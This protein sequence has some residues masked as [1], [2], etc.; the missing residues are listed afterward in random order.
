MEIAADDGAEGPDPVAQHQARYEDREHHEG[1]R[2][3]NGQASA[4]RGVGKVK[5]LDIDD[6]GWRPGPA[7]HDSL[8]RAVIAPLFHK[9]L[10]CSFSPA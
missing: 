9:E 4:A 10:R 1:P 7:R 5:H 3:E 2:P 8:S 6:A